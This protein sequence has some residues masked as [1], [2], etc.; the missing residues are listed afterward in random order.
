LALVAFRNEIA[1]KK[2]ILLLTLLCIITPFTVSAEMLSGIA[3]LVNDEPITT[4]DLAKE[5]QA[6]SAGMDASFSADTPA[7]KEHLR[8]VALD[9]LI[10]K[11]LIEQKIKELDI[12]VS[13]DEV[14]QAIEDVKKTNNISEENLRAA[15]AARGISYED[16]KAQ[17][18]DQ[19]ERLRLISLEVRSKIQITD[20]EIQEYYAAHAEK[21]QVDE[22]FRARQIFFAI[23]AK[24]TADEQKR[25]RDKA[26]KVLREA[27][28][29][30]DFAALA[31]KYSDDGSAK[32]GGDLG[33]LKKGE[34][35]PAFE[36]ALVSLKPGEVSSLIKTPVG[37]HIMKLEEHREG[38]QQGFES[39]KREVE[40]VLF[41]QKS[42]ER[43]SQ[44]LQG[45]RE[46]AAIEMR[47][48]K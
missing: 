6:L 43:F 12:K 31:K 19:L 36:N 14:K 35:L 32:E 44:W 46:K 28:G 7:A 18:K 30:A 39:V 4:Y 20:K 40:D 15:L 3:V 16:Y 47:D 21:F 38:K 11:K 9:S 48:A 42:E 29:G 34:L 37:L 41:K 13:D 5:Q 17:L 33:F 2:T 8:Q 26:E 25:I 10:N 1:M 45:L 27:Q 24:A 23:P 22:A